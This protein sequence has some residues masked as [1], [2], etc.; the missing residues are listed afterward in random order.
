MARPRANQAMGAWGRLR[1]GEQAAQIFRVVS[2]RWAT[3][4]KCNLGFKPQY[5]KPLIKFPNLP[6]YKF[7]LEFLGLSI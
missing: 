7:H 3:L 1:G 4:H 6:F 2:F 5:R